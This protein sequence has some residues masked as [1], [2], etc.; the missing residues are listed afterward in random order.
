MRSSS[1]K[2]SGT[3]TPVRPH[4]T[5]GPL[6]SLGFKNVDVGLVTW[7]DLNRLV[8]VAAAAV[9]ML[10]HRGRPNPYVTIL[11]LVCA[12]VGSIPLLQQAYEC[13]SQR[14][15]KPVLFVGAAILAAVLVG[16]IFLALV[17]TFFGLLTVFLVRIFSSRRPTIGGR[18]A[19][20][21]SFRN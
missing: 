3:T 16:R 11:T 6:S 12:I 2:K 7:R 10:V 19:G 20:V 21:R 8:F 13:I 14:R 4:E 17:I 18:G 5:A 9:L 15:T 1:A